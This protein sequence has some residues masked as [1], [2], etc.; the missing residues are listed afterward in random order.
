VQPEL[1]TKYN[2]LSF[3]KT[4]VG[5][6]RY[7]N[8]VFYLVYIPDAGKLTHDS[9]MLFLFSRKYTQMVQFHCHKRHICPLIAKGKK[10]QIEK[11]KLDPFCT[12][13]FFFVFFC[14][15]L[16]YG[17]VQI[18]R[19]ILSLYCSKNKERKNLGPFDEIISV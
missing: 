4:H 15:F 12:K 13:F 16:H 11:K 10:S 19:L 14:F 8:L 1:Q 6:Y 5:L 2:D 17:P 9:C 3:L 7:S 18:S